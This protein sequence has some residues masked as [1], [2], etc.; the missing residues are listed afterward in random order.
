MIGRGNGGISGARN[1][2]VVVVRKYG[3]ERDGGASEPIGPTGPCDAAEPGPIG[4][5]GPRDAV[6]LTEDAE[7]AAQSL[8]DILV[9]HQ[10]KHPVRRKAINGLICIN[11]EFID[12]CGAD[13]GH[14]LC[15]ET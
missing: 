10:P 4:P 5:T 13:V 1:M 9:D 12:W 7:I 6:G 3:G 15:E 11:E 14:E 2:V 8:A